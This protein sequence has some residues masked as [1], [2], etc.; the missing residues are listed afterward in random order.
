[1][2]IQDLSCNK[3]LGLFDQILWSNF[4]FFIACAQKFGWLSCQPIHALRNKTAGRFRSLVSVTWF[5]QVLVLLTSRGAFVRRVPHFYLETYLCKGLLFFPDLVPLCRSTS[6]PR[7]ICT[8]SLGY[9]CARMRRTQRITSRYPLFKH[10][11][12]CFSSVPL[13]I[14]QLLREIM[15]MQ[16]SPRIKTYLRYFS[17]KC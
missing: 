3:T 10:G 6:M 17:V 1:M 11:C 5:Q 12:N 4:H 15:K 8:C 13:C 16:N 9:P 14:S 2:C 7:F